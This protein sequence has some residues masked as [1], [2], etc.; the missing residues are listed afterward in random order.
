MIYYLLL[1]DRNN[2]EKQVKHDSLPPIYKH[3]L[4]KKLVSY[5]WT[6]STTIGNLLNGEVGFKASGYEIEDTDFLS[7]GT[8]DYYGRHIYREIV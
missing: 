4:T 7:D 8:R 5:D 3:A 1:I 6:G 2:F